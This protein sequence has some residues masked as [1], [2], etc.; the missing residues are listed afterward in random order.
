MDLFYKDRLDK[1]VRT[2]TTTK[3]F[4]VVNVGAL[5]LWSSD[6]NAHGDCKSLTQ[7]LDLHRAICVQL[8]FTFQADTAMLV[9]LLFHYY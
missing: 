7:L 3:S 4:Y 2:S 8:Q 5:I 1:T 9:E 6:S